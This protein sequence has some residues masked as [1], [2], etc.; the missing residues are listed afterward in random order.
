MRDTLSAVVSTATAADITMVSV[1]DKVQ[2]DTWL[3]VSKAIVTMVVFGVCSWVYQ[4][5]DL[6]FLH[7]SLGSNEYRIHILHEIKDT[8]KFTRIEFAI[9]KLNATPD[10]GNYLRRVMFTDN[11]SFEWLRKQAQHLYVGIVMAT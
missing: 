7:K 3:P 5:D 1:Q 10:D 6:E 2:R 4:N 8:E 11:I 9:L